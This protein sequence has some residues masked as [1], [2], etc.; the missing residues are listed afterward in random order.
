MRT[1]FQSK[2]MIQQVE[3][4]EW[5]SYLKGKQHLEPKLTCAVG[6]RYLKIINTVF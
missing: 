3:R 4:F 1:I 2:D 5:P 6:N